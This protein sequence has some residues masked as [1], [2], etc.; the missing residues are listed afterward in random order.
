MT[1]ILY[2]S[3]QKGVN[4]GICVRA[5]KPTGWAMGSNNKDNMPHIVKPKIPPPILT[6]NN[7]NT[8]PTTGVKIILIGTNPMNAPKINPIAI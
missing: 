6:R 2:K 4:A 5:I 8:H 3:V 7:N 1:G